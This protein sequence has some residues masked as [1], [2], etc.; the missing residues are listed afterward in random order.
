[1]GTDNM[2]INYDD[3]VDIIVDIFDDYKSY[4]GN[5]G[6]L[7]VCCPVCSYEI[8]NLD[9][10]DKKYNLEINIC[11][12]VFKCWSCAETH[13]TYGTLYKLIKNYGTPKDLKRYLLLK[14]DDGQILPVFKKLISLPKEYIPLSDVSN[15]F[16][17][18][19]HYKQVINYLK[20]RN[21][22]DDLIKKQKIGFCY[23]GHYSNMVIVPSY[24]IDNKLNYFIARSY[25]S[26]TKIKY[27]NPEVQKETIIWNEHFIDWSKKVYLVE[28][29]FDSIFLPNSIP[30]LG[31]YLSDLLFNRLYD[32]SES[33]TIILDG[34]AW[35]DT[36][37]L[38][39]RLNCGKLM[40]RVSV[41][42]LP[43]DKDIADLQGN[44]I[45]F[46]EFKL[47]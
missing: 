21:I 26:K 17:L 12:G 38:Y 28:G 27:K 13:D 10:L 8:K 47:D 29:V 4:N 9:E 23:T 24:D 33:I 34:D 3:L 43:K 46:P 39:H 25:L 42:K 22:N 37:R 30:M 44:L 14:P 31:K 45:D 36:E 5:T 18:T 32:K 16:K 15:G 11:R 2:E 1:M 19:H 6:Q 40:G 41:V 7:S 20:G 35:D